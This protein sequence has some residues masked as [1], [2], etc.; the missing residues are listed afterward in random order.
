MNPSVGTLSYLPAN[1]N[2]YPSRG[3]MSPFGTLRPMRSLRVKAAV[4]GEADM[5]GRWWI[6]R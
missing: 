1:H 6:G 2:G 5:R 3:A 4:G